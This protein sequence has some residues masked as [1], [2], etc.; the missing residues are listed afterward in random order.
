M[1]NRAQAAKNEDQRLGANAGRF[2]ALMSATK[3]STST[4]GLPK[5][6]ES[7]MQKLGYLN[8]PQLTKN[9][10]N[11]IALQ[12][13]RSDPNFN[14]LSKEAKVT[15]IQEKSALIEIEIKTYLGKKKI[16]T[17]ME[18]NEQRSAQLTDKIQ[19]QDTKL[20]KAIENVRQAEQKYEESSMRLANVSAEQEA[21]YR[22]ELR[23]NRRD[24]IAREGNIINMQRLVSANIANAYSAQG[25]AQGDL[26]RVSAD[27]SALLARIQQA[28]NGRDQR[29][30]LRDL[31][32]DIRAMGS[33]ILAGM[34]DGFKS[35]GSQLENDR[36]AILRALGIQHSRLRSQQRAYSQQQAQA[37]AEAAAAASAY[38]RSLV[39]R[40]ASERIAGDEALQTQ[41]D[42]INR[43]LQRLERTVL[44]L[45]ISFTADPNSKGFL[46]H[47]EDEK[48]IPRR[49]VIRADQVA[50]QDGVLIGRPGDQGFDWLQKNLAKPQFLVA[51]NFKKTLRIMPAK[52]A[53]VIDYFEIRLFKGEEGT[54]VPDVD[55][56]KPES[57]LK[58]DMKNLIE[59]EF[60]IRIEFK[61][62]NQIEVLYDPHLQGYMED[63]PLRQIVDL[64]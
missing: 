44:G 4:T 26:A 60:R 30:A 21:R 20:A 3:K 35:L 31:G 22:E 32:G 17:V 47:I 46:I 23:D 52:H 14:Q 38:A 34:Q 33:D 42:E 8:K 2:N 54:K 55:A 39:S 16:N 5:E 48:K 50:E 9:E 53:G 57:D 56:F 41:I 12:M 43:R 15:M 61:K 13:L 18:R 64:S 62:T 25:I 1:S 10:I 51:P 40:E 37:A 6:I 29:A 63:K 59:I 19:R 7:V 58:D 49:V 11:R 45:K 24:A 28:Q 27:R 36:E